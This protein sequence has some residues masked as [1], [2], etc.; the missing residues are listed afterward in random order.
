MTA[1]INQLQLLQQN[2]QNILVQKQQIE[3]QLSELNSAVTQLK[4]TEKAYKIVGKIMISASKEELLKDLEDKKEMNEIRLKNLIKQ[5]E[6]LKKNVE[7]VQK[8]VMKEM[9]NDKSTS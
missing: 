7:E 2:M 9:K 4:T 1:K 5:E 6:Q 3:S 8:E